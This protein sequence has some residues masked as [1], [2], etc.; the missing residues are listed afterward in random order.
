MLPAVAY[1]LRRAYWPRSRPACRFSGPRP[2]CRPFPLPSPTPSTGIL[3]LNGPLWT[4]HNHS[5]WLADY[6]LVHYP[7]QTFG[8]GSNSH[9]SDALGMDYNL[10]R[11]H[12]SYYHRVGRG[13]PLYA[14]VGYFLDTRWNIRT[15]NGRGE[16]LGVTS[17]YRRAG[18]GARPPRTWC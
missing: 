5:L 2:I 17:G 10:L 16:Q 6:R 1:T 14:G 4:S 11:V 7:Q 12:Q 18:A 13:G 3:A 9:V 15:F 8:L